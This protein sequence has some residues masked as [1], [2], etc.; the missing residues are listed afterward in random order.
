MAF[1]KLQ[2]LTAAYD[3]EI[4]LKKM[5]LE[6]KQG[7]LLSL[8]GSSGCGKTTTLRIVS[9][10]LKQLEGSVFLE[11]KEISKTHPSERGFGYVFQ[12]YA[13]FPHLN[14]GDNVSFGLKQRKFER[15]E[16]NKKVNEMLDMVDLTAFA[17]KRPLELSGGQRQRVALARALAISPRL[18]LMDEPLSNL[19]A[20]L[21]VKMRMEIRR[22]QQEHNI[23]ALY[24]T[25]DQEECFS[26]SDRV[27]V[28]NEGLIEQLG[29]PEEIYSSP[30]TSFVA[31]F[32]GFE[33]FIHGTLENSGKKLWFVAVKGDV[34]FPVSESSIPEH[35]AVV[36]AL[37]PDGLELRVSESLKKGIPGKVKV[38]TYL[39]KGYRHLVETE[40][41]ELVADTKDEMFAA[42]TNVIVIPKSESMILLSTYND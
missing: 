39:G 21:R 29:T 13:L 2:N 32:V 10:F 41:G 42:H 37:R 19:D 35:S 30:A 31:R 3:Q 15:E 12:N 25:H 24:V 23:T 26:I 20:A 27:A 9:G 7:E 36:A 18:L 40:L 33:N 34:R 17:G 28:M 11:G 5:N 4:V 8:L 22:I 38:A 6:V 1:L 14:V 16:I